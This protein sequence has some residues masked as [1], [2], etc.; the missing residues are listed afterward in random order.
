MPNAGSAGM[1]PP[2]Q[3]DFRESLWKKITN[4]GTVLAVYLTAAGH[5]NKKA[6]RKK[7]EVPL[8]FDKKAD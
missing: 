4:K 7:T 2:V 1:K 5:M 8:L 3:A 6:P